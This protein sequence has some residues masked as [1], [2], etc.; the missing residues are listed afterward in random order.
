MNQAHGGRKPDLFDIFI[1]QKGSKI[2]AKSN[3][4]EERARF[5]YIKKL[6]LEDC[7][8]HPFVKTI[9]LMI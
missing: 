8:I 2:I 5:W 6:C 1:K 7:F 9:L 4:N 3:H